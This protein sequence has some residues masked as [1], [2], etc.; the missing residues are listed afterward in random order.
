MFL[1]V[2]LP[3]GCLSHSSTSE[4]RRASSEFYLREVVIKLG[5]IAETK[6]KQELVGTKAAHRHT[7]T[8]PAWFCSRWGRCSGSSPACLCTDQ[9]C[10]HQRS[11]CIHYGLKGKVVPKLWNVQTHWKSKSQLFL[12]TFEYRKVSYKCGYTF[13][14]SWL[15]H[16]ILKPVEEQ[17]N[18][19][20]FQ[21]ENQ[22][23]TGQ[24]AEHLKAVISIWAYYKTI[25]TINHGNYIR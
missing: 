12:S 17:M 21:C 8:G 9:D 24:T 14:G 7:S 16:V 6:N 2:P 13:T 18:D 19:G 25:R 3:H 10:K 11:Q 5:N 1:Q 22:L 20:S 23:P 4:N 15:K